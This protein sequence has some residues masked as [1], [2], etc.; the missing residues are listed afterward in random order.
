MTPTEIAAIVSRCLGE[1]G[2][3]GI[4]SAYLF[5]SQAE[6]RAHRQSDVDIGVLLDPRTHPTEGARF[7]LRLRLGTMLEAALGGPRLDLVV[8]N[9]VPPGLGR[10]IVTA[11]RRLHCTDSELDHAFVRDIQLRAADLAPFL[12]RM[13]RIKLEAIAR[14]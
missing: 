7:E 2:F 12:Q 8:L 5:G 13:R 11:G 4:V 1:A 14:S 6:S 10:H 3:P 9:D